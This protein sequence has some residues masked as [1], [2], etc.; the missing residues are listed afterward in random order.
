MDKTTIILFCLCWGL[1]LCFVLSFFGERDT[2]EI[3]ERER[4][5]L[6]NWVVDSA[7]HWFTPPTPQ[8]CWEPGRQEDTRSPTPWAI[9]AA[10]RGRALAE[11]WKQAPELGLQPR[12]LGRTVRPNVHLVSFTMSG[13]ICGAGDASVTK[14]ELQKAC[15]CDRHELS[16]PRLSLSL[17]AGSKLARAILF[18]LANPRR[19]NY[20][21]AGTRPWRSGHGCFA[22]QPS[23]SSDNRKE[24]ELAG[25]KP[26][27][28]KVASAVF[29][30]LAVRPLQADRAVLMSRSS[31][32]KRTRCSWSGGVP[33]EWPFL[34]WWA[35]RSEF[36]VEL[37]WGHA[38]R[39]QMF[40]NGIRH[41][42]AKQDAAG[43]LKLRLDKIPGG[44]AFSF[45]GQ[46]DIE[47]TWN[48]SFV[49]D[50]P[51]ICPLRDGIK[52]VH[53]GMCF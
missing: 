35:H 46:C 38:R 22:W 5:S 25:M 45:S 26:T 51:K 9:S 43:G 33:A 50:K 19:S 3:W 12:P 32:R 30:L 21:T 52:C 28:L 27:D 36:H 13:A 17:K 31:V 40:W 23:S 10:S 16:S 6:I 2:R 1:L 49:Q 24:T 14:Q 47:D 39:P 7:I 41:C 15:D 18:L 42:W 20:S 48:V 44:L 4:D 53:S 29:P 11:S 34:W 8:W 37:T